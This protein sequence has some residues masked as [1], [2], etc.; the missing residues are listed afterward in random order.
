MRDIVILH[1][2]ADTE[3]AQKTRDHL[4]NDI[5]GRNSIIP[6]FT[7]DLFSEIDGG[8]T[9]M[10]SLEQLH[11]KYIYILILGTQNLADDNFSMFLN[12]NILTKGLKEAKGKEDRVLPIW[13]TEDCINKIMELS[14]IKGFKYYTF[15]ANKESRAADQY[16][17]FVR[18]TVLEGRKKFKWTLHAI[19]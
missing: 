11:D 15:L 8:R 10:R 19:P 1:T 6:N 9:A 18:K 17:Q 13:V 14:I 5:G 2:E 4:F 16:V 12:E 7:V 3:E